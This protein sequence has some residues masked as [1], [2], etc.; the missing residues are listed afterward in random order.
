MSE[1]RVSDERLAA[2]L[3]YNMK[4]SENMLNEETSSLAHDLRDAR[5]DNEMLREALASSVETI[6]S[7]YDHLKAKAGDVDLRFA[8][9]TLNACRKALAEWGER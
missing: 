7:L 5:A 2:I 9:R 1:Q 8:L 6:E 3:S 4:P